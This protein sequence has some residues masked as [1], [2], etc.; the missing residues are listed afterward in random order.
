MHNISTANSQESLVVECTG[1]IVSYGNHFEILQ[2]M[3]EEFGLFY[4]ESCHTNYRDSWFHY[5]KLYNKRDEISA[6]NEKYGIEEHLFRALKDAQIYFF[7]EIGVWLEF[8]Y[9]EGKYLMEYARQI[10]ED[11]DDTLFQDMQENWVKSIFEKTEHN[12]EKFSKACIYW[13]GNQIY[14]EEME[15]TLQG[16]LHS[17]KNLIFSLRVGGIDIS[18]PMDNINYLEK[19]VK[20][21]EKIC[22]VLWENGM[23]YLISST[24]IIL[25]CVHNGKLDIR[26]KE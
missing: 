12:S 21:Y 25:Q 7:Q 22:D 17:L 16:L 15:K 4:P 3:Y 8:W 1:L 10:Q 6:H 11:I 2:K 18:R 24:R 26:E 5:R 23:L 13:F 9:Y 14:S 20:I 19:A